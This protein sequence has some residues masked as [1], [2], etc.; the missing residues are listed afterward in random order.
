MKTRWI[1]LAG[2]LL[3]VILVFA[4]VPIGRERRVQGLGPSRDRQSGA[5]RSVVVMGGPGSVDHVIPVYS[6]PD[7]ARFTREELPRV[8]LRWG[9]VEG[10]R[11]YLLFVTDEVGDPIWQATVGDTVT[12]LPEKVTRL[13]AP[14]SRIKWVIYTREHSAS[15]DLFRIEILP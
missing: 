9:A 13:L 2:T 4:L 6:P 11:S 5:P 3:A 14:N 15:T 7:G 1:I 12:T 10:V 8:P